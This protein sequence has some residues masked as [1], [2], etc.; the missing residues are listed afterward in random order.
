MSHPD[1]LYDPRDDLKALEAYEDRIREIA[2]EVK[3]EMME[4]LDEH[5]QDT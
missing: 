2:N 5:R 1:P 3:Q 4:G